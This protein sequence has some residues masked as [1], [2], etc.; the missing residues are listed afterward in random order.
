MS[1]T[2]N[3][4]MENMEIISTSEHGNYVFVPRVIL[5]QNWE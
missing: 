5:K 3:S 4:D 1:M 2:I